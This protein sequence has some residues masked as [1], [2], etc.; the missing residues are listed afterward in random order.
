LPNTELGNL[1]YVEIDSSKH[2]LAQE[3]VLA[4]LL[5]RHLMDTSRAMR[6]ADEL[7]EQA[8]T[9]TRGVERMLGVTASALIGFRGFGD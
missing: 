5:S 8:A 6:D 3:K 9:V 2:P 4:K 7:V 1:A